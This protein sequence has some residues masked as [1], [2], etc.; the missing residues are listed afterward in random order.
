MANSSSKSDNLTPSRRPV[1]SASFAGCMGSENVSR[2]KSYETMLEI[3]LS[4]MSFVRSE[5]GA[6]MIETPEVAEDLGPMLKVM[7]EVTQDLETH[8]QIVELQ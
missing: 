7:Y 4:L 3:S 5:L 2:E 6:V 1:A 8:R